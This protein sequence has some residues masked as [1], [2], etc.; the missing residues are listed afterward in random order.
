MKEKQITDLI[1]RMRKLWTYLLLSRRK[2]TY[3]RIR[4]VKQTRKSQ[5]SGVYRGLDF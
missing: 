2:K 4:E 5:S 3:P 1:E